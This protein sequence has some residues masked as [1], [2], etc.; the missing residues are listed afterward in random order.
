VSR[1]TWAKARRLREAERRKA[2]MTPA[3]DPDSPA[4]YDQLTAG[5]TIPCT[6]E[7]TAVAE[8]SV[9]SKGGHGANYDCTLT[10]R[11]YRE[12]TTTP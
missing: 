11:Q 1:D 7:T 5:H 6:N 10:L 9:P 3:V 4:A 2:A 12:R 8:L